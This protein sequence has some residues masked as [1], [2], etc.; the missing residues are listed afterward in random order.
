MT[1]PSDSTLITEPPLEV[2]PVPATL[3]SPLSQLPTRNPSGASAG[4]SVGAAK[5]W[6]ARRRIAAAA[7]SPMVFIAR[8]PFSSP[9][10]LHVRRAH[11]VLVAVAEIRAHIIDHIG[12]LLVAQE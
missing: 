5:A 6:V 10:R 9:L 8:S 4:L 1:A 7:T 11:L 3:P 2:P 12:D